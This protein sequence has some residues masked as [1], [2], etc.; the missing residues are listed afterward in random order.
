MENSFVEYSW[1][2]GMRIYPFLYL[3]QICTKEY[4]EVID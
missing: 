3:N 1:I 4:Y 2:S